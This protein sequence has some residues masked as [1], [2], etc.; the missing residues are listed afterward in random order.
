MLPALIPRGGPRSGRARGRGPGV[1]DA[2]QGGGCREFLVRLE[3][4]VREEL[5]VEGSVQEVEGGTVYAI[6]LRVDGATML[7]GAVCSGGYLNFVVSIPYSQVERSVEAL[8][9]LL[10]DNL[11]GPG[12]WAI[13]RE[14]GE[15]ILVYT[16]HAGE[17][18]DL[19]EAMG[20]LA[21]AAEAASRAA[22]HLGL[23]KRGNGGDGEGRGEQPGGGTA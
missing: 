6:P 15:D 11:E 2:G 5:G 4:K 13:A 8:E 16:I 12:Y 3:E 20:L 21:L 1:T 14:A 22:P 10:R 19:D 18:G 17:P 9:W 7:L 23:S